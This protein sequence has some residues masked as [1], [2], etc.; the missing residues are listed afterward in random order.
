LKALL[1]DR[2]FLSERTGPE[3]REIL[4][5]SGDQFLQ[6]Q[7]EMEIR[8][9]VPQSANTI[10]TL[11]LDSKIKIRD[12]HLL[13]LSQLPFRVVILFGRD[14]SSRKTAIEQKIKAM[15]LPAGHFQLIETQDGASASISKF[16]R[17]LIAGNAY[18]RLDY[19]FIGT[20]RHEVQKVKSYVGNLVYYD[21]D[22]QEYDEDVL[23]SLLWYLVTS[24]QLFGLGKK[25]DICWGMKDAV[26]L[27]VE[28]LVTSLRS[29]QAVKMSA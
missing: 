29:Q 22:L 15:A 5:L 14:Q 26:M 2:D 21:K 6:L 13:L 17:P 7:R 24:P 8:R 3:L 18:Q 27:A 11:F 10:N 16:L 19:A 20:D 1:E 9:A 25:R 12:E 28:L 23:F 4:S